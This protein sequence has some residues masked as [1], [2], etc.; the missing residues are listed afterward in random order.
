M[1]KTKFYRV[2]RRVKLIH[3]YL[4][5]TGLAGW[6]SY[7]IRNKGVSLMKNRSFIIGLAFAGLSMQVFTLICSGALKQGYI[8]G[9]N[10]ASVITLFTA[11][12]L[13]LLSQPCSKDKDREREDLYRD[14]DAVYR[15]IDD[16]ARDLREDIRDCGRSSCGSHCKIGKK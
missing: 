7:K 16:T 14:I 6:Y 11:L 8:D 12:I 1:S 4:F 10:A 2:W 5:D 15:H 13:N 9:F 3:P